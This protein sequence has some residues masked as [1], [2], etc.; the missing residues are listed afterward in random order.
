MNPQVRGDIGS[1]AMKRL[2]DRVTAVD[3]AVV[4]GHE[5]RTVGG[6]VDGEVVEVVNGTETLLRGL[7][8]PDA[9]L[10]V[11]GGDTV[12]RGVHVAGADGV[13]A[14]LVTGPLSGEGLGELDDAGLGGVVA[15][16]LLRVVDDGARH[17]GD[18]DDRAAGLGLD[19]LLADGLG[20]EEGTGDVDVDEATELVV[21]V[22]LGLDVGTNDLSVKEKEVRAWSDLLGNAG[23]ID[24]D[25]ELAVVIDNV[26]DGLA[27]SLTVAHVDTIETDVDTSLLAKLTCSLL[28]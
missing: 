6:E 11:E 8:D 20:D 5:A 21:V 12:E 22:D 27:H 2:P 4:A 3:E 16:L 24:Q 14:D 26:L 25:I 18:V 28:S 7:V 1:S 19:H 10:S 13:D 15:R 9:L 23:S 17:G